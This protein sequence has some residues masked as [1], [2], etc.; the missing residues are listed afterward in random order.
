MNN[1]SQGLN[2][3]DFTASGINTDDEF[4]KIFFSD[5]EGNGA[6]AIELDKVLE[7]INYYTKTDDVRNHKGHTLDMIIEEFTGLRR[8]VGESD[9]IYLRRFLSITERMKDEVWGT[10]W[11]IKHVFEMYFSGIK[12]YVAENTNEYESNLLHNGDFEETDNAPWEL[13]GGAEISYSARFSGS[14]G[15]YFNRTGGSA[16]QRA[17]LGQGVHVFHF[18]LQGKAKV[19]ISNSWGEYWDPKAL[20]WV[21]GEGVAAEFDKQEW[22]DCEMFLK[23]PKPEG[24][25]VTIKFIA[26]PEDVVCIDY[27]RLFRKLKY[28][29]FTVIIQ[30][31][32]Y[33]IA[34]KTLHLGKG[35]EDPDPLI[36]WYPRE[37]YFDHSYIVGRAGAYRQEV[38]ESLLKIIKPLGIRAF[39]E[40]VEKVTED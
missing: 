14:R 10:K 7:F 2:L 11:N 40:T 27:V 39:I 15:L 1:S 35:K 13:E 24:D 21:W 16:S 38:Y 3:I 31:E 37:S 32:G 8:R 25:T 28:P 33:A 4:Y 6:A 12:A 34:D 29:A 17:E 22:D 23:I 20:Q 18:F 5:D 30:Y 19:E 26:A 36:N 9:R